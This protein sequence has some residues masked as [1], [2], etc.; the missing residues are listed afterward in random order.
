MEPRARKLKILASIIE[1]YVLTGEP[2]AS[3]A[4]AEAMQ[5]SVS[6]ATIRNDMAELVASG[7]LEQPHTS[8]GRI[9]SQRGYRLYV[10]HLMMGNH[11]LPLELQGEIDKRLAAFSYDPNKFLEVTASLIAEQTGLL[12]VVTNPADQHPKVTNAELMLIGVHSVMLLIMI[13]PATLKTRICRLKPELTPEIVEKLR[14]RLR[15]RLMDVPTESINE[16]FYAESAV[17]YGDLWDIL[18]PLFAAARECIEESGEMQVIMEG[19]SS[20]LARGV[21]AEWQLA[22]IMDFMEK[23]GAIADLLGEGNGFANSGRTCILIGNE[24]HRPEL[25][26][27]AMI[28]ERYYGGGQTAGWIGVVGPTRMNYAKLIP[29]IDYFAGA[30]GNMLREVYN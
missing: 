18:E 11:E 13:S 20:M 22:G 8:S 24:S 15:E 1:S 23:R 7:Y 29:Y 17:I 26:G 5:N 9:P 27:T 12:A 10:D 16:Q 25:E 14:R 3:K 19:Q 6:S 28:T 2:I 30:V 4:L 21:F